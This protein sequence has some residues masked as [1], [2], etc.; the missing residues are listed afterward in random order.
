MLDFKFSEPFDRGNFVELY[1]NYTKTIS[2]KSFEITE[3]KGLL[4]KNV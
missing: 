4:P 1:K 2:T 3:Y